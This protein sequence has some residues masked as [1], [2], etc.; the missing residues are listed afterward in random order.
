MIAIYKNKEIDHF[1]QKY[2]S[3]RTQ[4]VEEV[5]RNVSQIIKDVRDK[6]DEALLYYTEKFDGARLSSHTLSVSEEDLASAHK[7]MHKELLKVI[8]LSIQNV[9]EFH[10]KS[11]PQSWL[12]WGKD[13]VVLGQ[14]AIPLQRVGVY[15]PG[16]RAAYPSSLIM[17]VAPAQVAGVDE[18]YVVTPCN[19]EG[20]VNPVI[21]ATA[22]ELGVNKVFR[23]GGSQAIAGLAYGTETIS[24]VDKI[25]GPGN[26][27]VA[28]A[29]K[30]LYGQCGMDMIAGPSEVLV[31]ADEMAEAEFV[32]ADLLAQAEHD[33]LASALLVTSSEKLAQAVQK[34]VAEQMKHLK[35]TE[36]LN[37]SLANYGG[38]LLIHHLD[39]AI[40]LANRLAPE[41]LGLHVHDPWSVLGEIRTAG[42]I[43]L[44]SYSPE[45]VGD[46][47]AGPNHILPTNG[48]GRFF[49]PLRT[50][51]FFKFSSIISY[52]KEALAKN[53]DKIVQF[54]LAEGLDAH[55]KA[56]T[57]RVDKNGK[58][59]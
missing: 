6:G 57:K 11:I 1:L 48:S 47:W 12:D 8:Q 23:V 35:R 30:L 15:V 5:E 9:K 43:F 45:T 10:R 27:Y 4:M 3:R 37:H 17:G 18:I 34:A 51:D 31:I 54:A 26:I 22:Y 56:V 44:G 16:G 41:H 55:A 42:A 19:A 38:I 2:E 46:Y 25:V 49:S 14:R 33:P 52:S 59:L 50:E 53:A 40:V 32:A 21:L 7:K 13:G 28:T 20:E 36:I 58:I 24:R 29:K 39:D